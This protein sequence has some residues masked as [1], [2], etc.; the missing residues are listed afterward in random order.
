MSIH[1]SLR[2]LTAFCI[3]AAVFLLPAC[4]E[5]SSP[6]GTGGGNG[7]AGIWYV[8]INA[9]GSSDGSSWEDAFTSLQ[10][11]VDAA[12]TGEQV[13]VAAGTYLS[14]D[15]AD[16]LVPVLA[17]KKKVDIYGG[18]DGTEG[19]LGERDYDVNVTILDGELSAYHVVTG[20]DT[21]RLDGFTITRG[22]AVGQGQSQDGY[23]GG[24]LNYQSSPTVAN[25]TFNLNRAGRGGGIYNYNFNGQILNCSF[26]FNSALDSTSTADGGGG[27]YNYY[28]HADLAGCSFSNNYS[29]GRGGGLSDMKSSS[30]ID[31]CTF[32]GNTAGDYGGGI[33]IDGYSSFRSPDITNCT[34]TGCTAEF[35]GGIANYISNSVITGCTITG[36]TATHHGAGLYFDSSNSIV[37]DCLIA[38]NSSS[39]NGGGIFTYAYSL[40]DTA[41]DITNCMIRGNTASFDGGGI[42]N[43]ENNPDLSLCT[44]TGNTASRGGSVFNRESSP[45]LV[46]VISWGNDATT[47]PE[48]YD[49]LSSAPDVTYSNIQG[50]FAGTGNMNQDPL[51]VSGPGG[52]YYLSQTASGQGSDSPCVNAGSSTAEALGMV[53]RSTRTDHGADTGVVDL[54]YHY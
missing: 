7:T 38:Q 6:T 20:A 37:T 33:Y 41:P 17:M 45:L 5:D 51:W 16:P 43:Y 27:V 50:G 46:N 30:Q 12:S 42:Y 15:Q 28:S 24:M 48:I 44:I 22:N 32:S 53:D 19:S 4:S 3:C 54:G 10:D 25:C 21:A 14:A 34:I 52:N 31:S 36:N 23:G 39:N 1:A 8:D 40:H 35:G 13:W 9:T 47:G 49:F 26:T 2:F 29:K 18:F 11:A